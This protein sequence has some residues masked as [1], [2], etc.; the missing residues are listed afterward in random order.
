MQKMQTCK[1]LQIKVVTLPRQ[2][3]VYYYKILR[4]LT[5]FNLDPQTVKLEISREMSQCTF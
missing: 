1:I 5:L 2:L 4:L 3:Y